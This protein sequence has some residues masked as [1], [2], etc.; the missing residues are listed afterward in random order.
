MKN[1]RYFTTKLLIAVA[2]V[3]LTATGALWEIRGVRAKPNP[4]PTAVESQTSFGA[5]GI[6]AGQ[7]GPTEPGLHRPLSCFNSPSL[8]CWWSLPSS[9]S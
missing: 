1:K 7:T 5:I 9:R 2:L 8:S 6:A 3:A 4:M